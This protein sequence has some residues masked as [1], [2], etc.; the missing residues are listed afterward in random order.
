MSCPYNPPQN[1]KG[2]RM[3][4]TTNDVMHSL[5]FQT[6]LLARYW[7]ES[8]HTATY[9]LN[10]LPTKAIS[11]PSPHFAL[12][13]ATPSYAHLRVFGCACYPNLSA[14]APNKLASRSS[15]CV[16]LGYSSEHK[17]YRC[18]DLSSN[19]IIISRHVIFDESS[20]PFASPG[21]PPPDDLDIL[22]ELSPTVSPIVAP[23]S[24]P[25]SGTSTPAVAP[26][27]APALSPMPHVAP[28]LQPA[29]HAAPAA[30]PLACFAEPPQVYQR[31]QPA[32]TPA[33]APSPVSGMT[34]CSVEPPQVSHWWQVAPTPASS[35]PPPHAPDGHVSC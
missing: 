29:P 28:T 35:W 4:H 20:F 11:A 19:R 2:E 13:G 26:R 21:S 31:C 16:F 24:S 8:L 22:F 32:S 17:G 14:I 3:I 27:A 1:G 9:L 7:V 10:L 12:F 30:T 34:S 23:P 33:P 5:L 25:V 18:L 6:S 15:R